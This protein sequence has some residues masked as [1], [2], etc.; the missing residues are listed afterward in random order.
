M[1]LFLLKPNGADQNYV[2]IPD[3]LWSVPA[4][5]TQIDAWV[6]G[7][8][9]TWYVDSTDPD[10]LIQNLATMDQIQAWIYS[11]HLEASATAPGAAGA[12]SSSTLAPSPAPTT[13]EPG[14]PPAVPPPTSPLLTWA[15]VTAVAVAVAVAIS[16][17]ARVRF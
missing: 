17:A 1:E 10:P 6:K 14:S 9:F 13:L 15:I 11:Q 8:G 5:Q 3:A 7:Q 2:N 16:P 4:N 12:A